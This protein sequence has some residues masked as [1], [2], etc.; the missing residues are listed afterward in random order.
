M[1]FYRY[2]AVVYA[3][4]DHDGELVAPA[5]RIPKIELREYR[6][7]RETP[8]GY[9]IG[10]GGRFG[11]VFDWKKWVSK[12]AKKRFAYPTKEEAMQ[13]YI[14]RTEMRI[15]ILKSQLEESQYGLQNAKSMQKH[16]EV[17]K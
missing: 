12:T 8:K 10:F 16:L 5:I 15:R 11:S 4:H 14:K 2:E 1:K 13:N 6:L 7:I 9:W 17:Q 3:E